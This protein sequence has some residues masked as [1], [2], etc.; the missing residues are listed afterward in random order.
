MFYEE[1]LTGKVGR[2]NLVAL[3]IGS[4]L[5]GNYGNLET[6]IEQKLVQKFEFWESIIG[7]FHDSTLL[8]LLA[9]I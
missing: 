1:I 8:L 2:V 9:L 5:E 4:D 3:H 6:K 7:G